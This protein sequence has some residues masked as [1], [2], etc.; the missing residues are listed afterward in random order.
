MNRS[1]IIAAVIISAAILLNGYLQ[2]T[3]RTPNLVPPAEKAATTQ[4][5]KSVAVLPFQDLSSSAE[6]AGF[7][8]G[9]QQEITSRLARV[10]DLKVAT[11]SDVMRYKSPPRNL[12]EVGR[13]LGVAYLVEGRV[14]RANNR[15]R[16]PAQL[17][18]AATDQ[19]L[20]AE[21]YDR[22]LTD[23]LG[24][25]SEVAIRIAEQV[26]AKLSDAEKIAIERPPGSP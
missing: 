1:I 22:D 21:T 11:Q 17:V 25:E 23:L 19:H 6:N 4:R 26:G 8:S 10:H 18:V 13:Q 5:D 3:A 14:Q 2:R 9:V 7:A 12:R 20:W 15:V 24:I 16:V